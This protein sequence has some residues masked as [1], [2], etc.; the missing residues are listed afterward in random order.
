MNRAL[1]RQARMP[2]MKGAYHG[3]AIVGA[4]F[5]RLV[6]RARHGS[7]AECVCDCGA[8]H[9]AQAGNLSFGHV[10]SCG[11][12]GREARTS[13]SS[14]FLDGR[15]RF[16]RLEFVREVEPVLTSRGRMARKAECRCD[17]G[18]VKVVD[19]DNL[20]RG[21]IKSCGCAQREAARE[22]IRN[23]RKG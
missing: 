3:K 17:C 18:T 7:L 12:L 15:T 1:V 10:Q 13:T 5:G 6:V 23:I 2:L 9:E 21:K 4:R 8:A 22:F 11:C 19:M 20:R 16:E 14:S